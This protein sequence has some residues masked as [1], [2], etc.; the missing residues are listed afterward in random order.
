MTGTQI[1]LLKQVCQG[2]QKMEGNFKKS[3]PAGL[4]AERFIKTAT[5]AIQMHAQKDKLLQA[6]RQ[7][8]YNAC[9][10]A[11]VDGLMLDGSQAALVVFKDQVTYMPMTQ[12]LV[13]LA[14]NSGEIGSIVAEVVYKKDKFV[15]RIGLDDMPLHEPDWFGERGEP[16][17]VWACVK[18]KNG[19]IISRL[20]PKDKVMRIAGKSK[21]QFQYDPIKG[22]YF[23]EWWRKTAIKNVLKYAPKSSELEVAIRRG[24]DEEFDHDETVDIT[25]EP[26]QEPKP[27]KQTRAAKAVKE[28]EKEEVLE[29]EIIEEDTDEVEEEIPV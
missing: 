2:L 14:R 20:L 22:P 16:I 10:K 3:L 25:P 5:N 19:E 1:T 8:L 17:G 11:A 23:D 26:E 12:G 29:A 6:D 27:K 7:S 13:K 15:Y 4:S 9:Q 28:E 21:N 24:D 18:L